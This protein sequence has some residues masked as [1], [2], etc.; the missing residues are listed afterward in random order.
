MLLMP[1]MASNIDVIHGIEQEQLGKSN[2]IIGI[3]V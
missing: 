1:G 2:V 3:A